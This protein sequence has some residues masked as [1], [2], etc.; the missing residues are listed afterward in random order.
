MNLPALAPGGD[1]SPLVLLLDPRGRISRRGFWLWGVGVPIGLGI[2][3]HALLGIARV[4]A[5]TAENIVNLV[6]L[7]PALAVSIKRWH[8]RNESGWWVLVAL[9]PVIGWAYM[10]FVNGFLRG[11]DG[12]NRYGDAPL[13]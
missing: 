10:L 9:V 1:V 3:L 7:W 8:D 12:P 5:E 6:L 11:T 2:V 4:K 13:R